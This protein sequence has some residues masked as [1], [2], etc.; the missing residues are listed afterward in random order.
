MN[1]VGKKYGTQFIR[2]EKRK[3]QEFMQD[4][5]RIAVD[6]TFTQINTKRGIDMHG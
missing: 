4:I 6:V 2:N 3:Y 5:H 1:F